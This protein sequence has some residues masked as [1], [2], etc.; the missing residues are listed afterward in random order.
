MTHQVFRL[1]NLQ[2]PFAGADFILTLR[3][4]KYGL[5]EKGRI[6]HPPYVY[7]KKF[8]AALTVTQ[9]PARMQNQIGNHGKEQGKGGADAQSQQRRGIGLAEKAVAETVNQIK[10]GIGAA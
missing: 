2:N 6:C 5:T 10:N 9:F 1:P 7:E 4:D 3:H 8:Q